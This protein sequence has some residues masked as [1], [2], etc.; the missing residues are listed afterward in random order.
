[1]GEKA[2][3]IHS[4]GGIGTAGHH[5]FSGKGTTDQS[6]QEVAAGH[7]SAGKPNTN[8]SRTKFC[9]AVGDTKIGRCRVTEPLNGWLSAKCVEVL[10]QGVRGGPVPRCDDYE[11]CFEPAEPQ[12]VAKKDDGPPKTYV[13]ASIKCVVL[14]VPEEERNGVTNFKVGWAHGQTTVVTDKESRANTELYQWTKGKDGGPP[15][16]SA[17][18]SFHGF[19]SRALPPGKTMKG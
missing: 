13:P 6:G 17:R 8:V 9:S 10:P 1:M 4:V 11:A 5:H 2:T 16:L 19:A 14:N 18:L 15:E 7:I 3:L 12:R